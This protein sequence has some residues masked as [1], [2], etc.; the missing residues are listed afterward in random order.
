M[1]RIATVW[2]IDTIDKKEEEVEI[3]QLKGRVGKW[4]LS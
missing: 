4:D 2:A 1:E 3:W